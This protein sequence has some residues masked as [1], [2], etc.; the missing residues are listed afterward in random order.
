MP[1]VRWRHPSTHASRRSTPR[2]GCPNAGDL[3]NG[4]YRIEYTDAYLQSWGVTDIN[5]Q[6]GIWTYRLKDG[7]WTI[8]QLADD[9]TD[10]DEGTYQVKGHDLDWVWQ[11]E[12]GQPVERLTWSVAK[13]GDLTFAAAPGGVEGWTF[14]LPLIRVGDLK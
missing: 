3:P 13:N 5:Y 9:I 10:H 4:I 6:H 7:H 11:G 1:P 8:D 2:P 14:G 12:P